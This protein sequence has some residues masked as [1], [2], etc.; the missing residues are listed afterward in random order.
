MRML[1]FAV[2]VSMFVQVGTAIAAEWKPI[3]A[4]QSRIFASS[5]SGLEYAETGWNESYSRRAYR[6]VKTDRKP[7]DDRL[8]LYYY[9]PC[10]SG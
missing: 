6:A 3:S 5:V 4:E 9:E 2:S 7:S 8:E 10:L 1:P